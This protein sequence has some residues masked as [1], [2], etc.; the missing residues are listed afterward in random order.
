MVSCRAKKRRENDDQ[1]N[2]I[3]V[4]RLLAGTDNAFSRH[5]LVSSHN[6]PSDCRP[7]TGRRY[8]YSGRVFPTIFPARKNVDG[9]P[10]SSSFRTA[11]RKARGATIPSSS[12]CP[13]R[14]PWRRVR[15]ERVR[16]TGKIR[17]ARDSRRYEPRSAIRETQSGVRST[18]RSITRARFAVS[19]DDDD[20]T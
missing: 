20:A 19:N 17:L 16:E 18:C 9:I 14:N 8:F 10:S 2:P 6:R 13:V 11:D 12:V 3:N 5:V 15:A 1:E 4:G 7:R